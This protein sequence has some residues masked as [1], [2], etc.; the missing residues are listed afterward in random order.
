M[1][2]PI[3]PSRR[4]GLW[5]GGDWVKIGGRKSLME[6]S[7]VSTVFITSSWKRLSPNRKSRDRT[8]CHIS[9]CSCVVD[10]SARLMP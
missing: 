1:K 4:F 10:G 6:G 5:G 7:I 2:I 8:V 3:A 9:R